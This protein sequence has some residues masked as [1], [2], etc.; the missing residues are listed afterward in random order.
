MK[1]KRICPCEG[2]TLD[3]MLQ[4]TVM[5]L[6]VEEPLHGYALIEKLK[7]SPLMKGAAPDPTGVYRLLNT[8]EEQGT[9]SHTW[10]DSEEGPAKR[11]Y[12]LTRSGRECVDK[13]IDTLDRYQRDVGRLVRVMRALTRT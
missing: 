10:S 1:R 11:L 7:D 3:R 12:R 6:L 9:V 8:L 13:W 4:P 2:H 5:A